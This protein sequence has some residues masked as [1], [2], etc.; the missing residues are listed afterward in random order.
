MNTVN[1]DIIGI[2][3]LFRI[4]SG[5]LILNWNTIKHFNTSIVSILIN[6]SEKTASWLS[7]EIN[8]C[9][10]DKANIQQET[11][12]NIIAT[13]FEILRSTLFGF[14]RNQTV[15]LIITLPDFTSELNQSL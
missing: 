8:F 5:Q 10:I 9:E 1:T 13:L 6:S 2:F 11:I 3:V 14:S 15:K 7:Q 12:D 4:I